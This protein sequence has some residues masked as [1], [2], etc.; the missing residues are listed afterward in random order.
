MQW[1]PSARCG[2]LRP[3]SG[4]THRVAIALQFPPG[5]VVPLIILGVATKL[6]FAVAVTYRTRLWWVPGAVS[7][8]IGTLAAL[9][10]PTRTIGQAG[11]MMGLVAVL[12]ARAARAGEP[13]R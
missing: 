8:G 11:I 6:A 3:A 1:Q 7:A 13:V 9:H 5:M 12:L 4:A 2:E 10:E